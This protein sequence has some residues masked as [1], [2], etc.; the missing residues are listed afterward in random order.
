MISQF[1]FRSI[2]LALAGAAVAVSPR[3]A[4]AQ[5]DNPPVSSFVAPT[6]IFNKLGLV[7]NRGAQ[8]VAVRVR[9]IK[10]TEPIGEV[11]GESNVA[12]SVEPAIGDLAPKLD[13]ILKGD[14]QGRL[15]VDPNR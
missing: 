10:A 2:L 8:Q 3:T 9:V 11:S 7:S 5:E 1:I 13:S 12:Q 14:V 4:R 6:G 15:L